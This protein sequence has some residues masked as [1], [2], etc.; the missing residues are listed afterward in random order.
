MPIKLL[1]TSQRFRW[2][3]IW[4]IRPRVCPGMLCSAA[5]S[6]TGWSARGWTRARKTR[7]RWEWKANSQ[8]QI[9]FS[10]NLSN[11]GI[12]LQG[13][14]GGPL[15]NAVDGSY[16]LIGV[17]S[18][19]LECAQPTIPGVY[20]NVLGKMP[21]YKNIIPLLKGPMHDRITRNPSIF[22]PSILVEELCGRNPELSKGA[23][24][25]GSKVN[26]RCLKWIV[27]HQ[28]QRFLLNP[29]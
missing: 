13:D 22:S 1:S 6:P 21:A 9:H 12:F 3:W 24:S 27:L 18:F 15:I 5:T 2:T 10:R 16:E 29:H 25:F 11:P 17:V 14:S 20:A 26:S 8:L 7:A 28:N 23:N 4:L 19:G